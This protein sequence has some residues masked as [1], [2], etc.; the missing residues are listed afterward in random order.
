MRGM[1]RR[2]DRIAFREYTNRRNGFFGE[3]S[4]MGK[5]RAGKQAKRKPHGQ[6]R[7]LKNFAPKPE[8]DRLANAKRQGQA[9]FDSIKEMVE[10]LEWGPDCE[11]GLKAEGWREK[12]RPADRCSVFERIEN[13]ES[14]DDFAG[15]T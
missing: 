11:A 5:V 14:V 4:V 8:E 15:A 1:G 3:E 7:A 9:Q 6:T 2:V 12:E 10:A 13:G